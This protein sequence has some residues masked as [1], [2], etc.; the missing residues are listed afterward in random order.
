MIKNNNM[1]RITAVNG[2]LYYY[3]YRYH[4]HY[5]ATV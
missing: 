3:H 1:T 4:Y 2:T 5:R